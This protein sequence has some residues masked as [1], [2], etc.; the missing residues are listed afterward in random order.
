[1]PRGVVVPIFVIFINFREFNTSGSLEL[2][3]SPLI[4]RPMIPEFKICFRR[5][6]IL[7]NATE[8]KVNGKSTMGGS[9]TYSRSQWHI[10]RNWNHLPGRRRIGIR[11]IKSEIF[12]QSK[13]DWQTTKIQTTNYNL[14]LLSSAIHHIKSLYWSI[15]RK[16]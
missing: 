8:C 3:I 11:S 2:R 9:Y 6:I 10:G 12:N 5:A 7:S 4:Y 16:I 15:D 1:M 14:R 13:S